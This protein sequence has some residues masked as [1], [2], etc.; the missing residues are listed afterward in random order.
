[1]KSFNWL[2]VIIGIW[3]ILSPFIFGYQAANFAFWNSL[4]AGLVVGSLGLV[5]VFKNL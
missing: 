3:L 5:I 1:M 2:F 4:L